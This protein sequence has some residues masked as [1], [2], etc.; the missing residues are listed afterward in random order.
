MARILVL[1]ILAAVAAPV[2]RAQQPP[3][4]LVELGA[5][6]YRIHAELADRDESRTIGLM[7]RTS[8]A[9]SSGMLFLFD[10]SAE[11]CMWMKNTLLPLSV[12]FVDEHGTIVNIEDMQP[13]TED[14]H[15]AARPARF[16]LEMA[17]GWFARR[18]IR[19]G[20]RLRGVEKLLPR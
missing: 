11:H 7:Q 20:T 6:L 12:A 1:L 15:C 2:A 17:Q 10:A 5:G 9:P 18:G 13:Q 8:L 3:L 4:P 19:A 16:A 14:S